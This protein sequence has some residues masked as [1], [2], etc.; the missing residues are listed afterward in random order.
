MKKKDRETPAYKTRKERVQITPFTRGIEGVAATSHK[1]HFSTPIWSIWMTTVQ[2][3]IEA[4]QLVT[5]LIRMI[6]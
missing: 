6:W 4:D 1:L 2:L 5:T 3:G